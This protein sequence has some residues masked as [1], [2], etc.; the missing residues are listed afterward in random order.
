VASLGK[1]GEIPV[2]LY[3]GTPNIS[4]PLYEISEGPLSVPISLSYHAAGIRVEEIA[5][6]VGLGWALNAGGMVSKQIRGQDDDIGWVKSP[7]NLIRDILASGTSSEKSSFKQAL[8][9]G[10]MDGEPDIYYYNFNGRSGKFLF[11]EDGTLYNYPAE[12]VSIVGGG[13]GNGWEII[14][15]DGTKYEFA[16]SKAEYV[17][18][19]RICDGS[20]TEGYMAWYLTK[21][22][23]A[24]GK[25]HVDFVYEPITY[26]VEMSLGETKYVTVFPGDDNC[27]PNTYSS[28][29]SN[30][31]YTTHRLTQIN[32]SGGRVDFG[33]SSQ[34]RQDLPGTNSLESVRVYSGSAPTD[35]LVKEYVFGYSYFGAGSTYADQKR[36]KL[37]TLTETT[38]NGN[39]PPH[40][41][42]YEESIQMPSRL[43]SNK[44][45]WGYY[46]GAN[47]VGGI[48]TLTYHYDNGNT[49]PING[50]AD[51]S[52]NA[53]TMQACILK[54]ITYP[55]GGETLFT[56]ET[57]E[58]TDPRVAV[59]EY[60]ETNYQLNDVQPWKTY[61]SPYETDTFVVPTGEG[62]EVSF[63]SINGFESHLGDP[64]YNCDN[65][66]WVLLKDG[67]PTSISG[68][69]APESDPSN[70]NLG[71]NGVT[72]DLDPGTYKFQFNF[73]CPPDNQDYYNILVTVKTPVEVSGNILRYVGGLRIKQIEDRPADGGPSVVK[74]YK[75]PVGGTLVNFPEYGYEWTVELWEAPNYIDC[76]HE[77][78]CNYIVVSSSTNYPLATTN[79]SYVG[80]GRV[81][82]D[83]GE[84]GEVEHFY[85]AYTDVAND[86]P[87][88]PLEMSDWQRGS[89]LQTNHYTFDGNGQ[90]VP[91]KEVTYSY[92][93]VPKGTIKGYKPSSQYVTTGC[94]QPSSNPPFMTYDILPD[95][96]ILS[97]VTERLYD[98]DDPSKFVE[99][100]V[101][102]GYDPYHYQQTEVVTTVSGD[103][104]ALE[105]QLVVKRKFPQDY[106]TASA[107]GSEALGI[108]TLNDLHVV[109]V[110][111]EEYV[112]RQKRD[113]LS[114][115]LSDQHVVS[116]TIT[117]FKPFDPY[118]DK[119]F[120]LERNG[121][122]SLSSFGAGST[123]VNNVFVKNTNPTINGSYTPAIEFA[124]YDSD[125][126]L[127]SQRMADG[128]HVYY[129]WGYNGRYPIAK[130]E[131]F[132]T[133]Q[134]SAV[135]ASLIDP[136]VNASNTDV[137]PATEDTLRTKLGD[138]RTA[139]ALSG[140]MVTTYTYDPLVG[141]TSV[142]D[143]RGQTVY[144]EYDGFNRLKAVRDAN[145]KI[146]ST[147]EYHYR[148]Q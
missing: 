145:G 56:Y 60:D 4:I 114:G 7:G 62:V 130:I 142:T 68:T 77:K 10:S 21:I 44:D 28:C 109:N 27:I 6:N 84:R 34:D 120:R 105:D 129:I 117:T 144:Y 141:V 71:L 14:A 32:F 46:N 126:N 48:P 116:G 146:L 15:E 94:I 45:H 100:R 102:Y 29:S 86:F 75:Y 52:A 72:L 97:G 40:V 59:A 115:Q 110:P 18:T 61:T 50:G 92:F 124:T 33:Y 96:Y 135:Q 79:G 54:K 98:E 103:G 82:E 37:D 24:D 99:T 3:T 69:I 63:S 85:R 23:S 118:P 140:A 95:F 137:S 121:A 131:N 17:Y 89:E 91:K 31:F 76:H 47:N 70:E 22:T 20:S 67:V 122:M 93:N 36:L 74:N 111:I 133:S 30:S 123:L 119:I 143:P 112:F 41:F 81:I 55:T 87:F 132:S 42:T 101:S 125:G 26:N 136:A 65:F 51:R 8:A 38:P 113:T 80:Y 35:E 11:D 1:Y 148:G 16:A 138:L 73:Y 49:W 78:T 58:S 9:Y 90:R 139:T 19:G 88:P 43:S 134:A 13:Y 5:S 12:N 106:S 83:L 25:R 128:T 64:L 107:S 108:Q 57:N 127:A 66:S 104:G 39:K 53:A 2:G 147:N